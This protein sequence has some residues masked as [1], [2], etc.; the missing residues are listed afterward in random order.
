MELAERTGLAQS[1][2]S[3]IERGG[4]MTAPTA[5]AL[6]KALGVTVEDLLGDAAP[7][8]EDLAATGS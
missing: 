5:L 4:G 7:E 3:R 1:T 6:A 2:I 8:A